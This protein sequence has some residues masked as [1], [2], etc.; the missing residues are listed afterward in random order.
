M[1]VFPFPFLRKCG[2]EKR[3]R[4]CSF[5]F[6]LRRAVKTD[7]RQISEE[8]EEEEMLEEEDRVISSDRWFWL[9]AIVVV[10]VPMR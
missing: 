5:S 4:C 7:A 3:M 8:E 1:R 2:G 10:V 9:L 6:F